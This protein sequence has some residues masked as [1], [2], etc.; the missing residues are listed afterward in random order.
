MIYEYK[1]SKCEKRFDENLSI[2]N[3][4][5]PC[6]PC[7]CPEGGQIQRCYESVGM[8]Y[9]GYNS[10]ALRKAGD[11]WTDVLKKI[12]KTSGRSNTIQHK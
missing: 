8:H 7:G 5:K 10:S 9:L 4:D 11:G 1:C 6:G 12:K 3:R 2:E